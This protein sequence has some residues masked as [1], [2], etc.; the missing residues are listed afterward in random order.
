MID[1]ETLLS[2]AGFVRGVA[3][4]L[5]LDPDLAED[6]VQKTLLTALDRPP[7]NQKRL[8]PW[9]RVVARNFALKELRQRQQ[10][11]RVEEELSL[12]TNPPSSPE[13]P[14]VG[15]VHREVAKAVLD[16][17]EPYRSTV[18]GLYYEDLSP[19]EIAARDGV[20]L[21]TVYTRLRRA[22]DRLR[23]RL[24]D[25]GGD[26]K[27]WQIALAPLAATEGPKEPKP[28]LH[29]PLPAGNP[30]LLPSSK[31]RTLGSLVGCGLAAGLLIAIFFWDDPASEIPTT[32]DIARSGSTAKLP[33]RPPTA[34]LEND[35][36][37]QTEDPPPAEPVQEK[38]T[39]PKDSAGGAFQ[40]RVFF[41][42][43]EPAFPL[44]G[45]LEKMSDSLTRKGHLMNLS[46]D[47]EGFLRGDAI[48]PGDYCLMIDRSRAAVVLPIRAGETAE[49][50]LDL[51]AG[52][53]C[54]GTVLDSRGAPVEGAKILLAS[55]AWWQDFGVV[56]AETDARGEF[57]VGDLTRGGFLGARAPGFAPSSMVSLDGQSARTLTP[58]LVLS[59]EGARVI[60]T[61]THHDGT[62][63]KGATIVIERPESRRGMT[64]ER[65]LEFIPPCPTW[66]HTDEQGRF[67]AFSLTPG[68]SEILIAQENLSALR[69]RTEFVPGLNLR[70]YV[71]PEPARLQGTVNTPRGTPLSN[72]TV[73]VIDT[74]TCA[75]RRPFET[76]TDEEGLFSIGEL[77]PGKI[78][79]KIS[80]ERGTFRS[81]LRAGPGEVVT[82][83]IVLEGSLRL[84]GRLSSEEG[85]PLTG[86][87]IRTWAPYSNH[88]KRS[89]SATPQHEEGLVKINGAQDW[90]K[91]T[92]WMRGTECCTGTTDEMGVFSVSVPHDLLHT[93]QVFQPAPVSSIPCL[94]V[95]DLRPSS[96][97]IEIRVLHDSLPTAAITG[98]VLD[99]SGNPVTDSRLW[100]EP[101]NLKF[102][103][104]SLDL[105]P[106][107][108]FN[109]GPLPESRYSLI[110]ESPV[111]TARGPSR[112]VFLETVD[113]E[114]EPRVDLGTVRLSKPGA[115]RARFNFAETDPLH[116]PF[117]EVGDGKSS[118]FVPC[119]LGEEGVVECDRLSPGDYVL[120]VRSGH[121]SEVAS[122]V[123]PFRI[124]SGKTTEVQ[125]V[126][127]RGTRCQLEFRPGPDAPQFSLF[128][129]LR[130]FGEGGEP[131]FL[132]QDRSIEGFCLL[133]GTYRAE[134]YLNHGRTVRREFT[135]PDDHR[136]NA[137]QN[138][139]RPEGGARRKERIDF[140]V[141]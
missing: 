123:V 117:F 89:R 21:R 139:T 59:E 96:S 24:D 33:N 65:T 141:E 4:T 93:I 8:R 135:I 131:V 6:V 17:D 95:R 128:T 34:L 127:Q 28:L 44:R 100:I 35:V 68:K 87:T 13:D 63:V 40:V 57:R 115:L 72:A 132:G 22:S 3:R 52:A 51:P 79:L 66:A 116:V 15:S 19:K 103:P 94:E 85:H 90:T 77:A 105:E 113:L 129:S 84:T 111:T 12:S 2:H 138:E 70:D 78:R 126:L 64:R 134:A 81:D 58:E 82:R 5:L 30:T 107:G 55:D 16:L 88:E 97:P 69:K 114:A 23:Q 45:G 74:A 27:K 18:L 119:V 37:P 7:R 26:R 62:P 120:C 29:E 54:K 133:P 125:L 102:L 36:E 41:S 9:L 91:T 10:R 49:M 47:E 14:D 67:E 76:E 53:D 118:F 99:P 11:R 31:R 137:H 73:T 130:I 56:V 121:M 83:D 106:S 110:L 39:E 104:T 71:L 101:E 46:T 42:N 20:P 60:G 108:E 48:P 1:P 136:N 112:F 50:K 80:H 75:F 140:L 98:R 92:A 32:P 25:V 109:C 124:D 61:V 43:G 86:W 122:T 38:E